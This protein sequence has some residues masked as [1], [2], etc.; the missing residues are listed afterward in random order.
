VL[1]I[2]DKNVT[3]FLAGR[4]DSEVESVLADTSD[5]LG[6]S[7]PE[8]RGRVLRALA[9]IR[10]GLGPEVVAKH[11]GWRE[12]ESF[13]SRLLGASGYRVRE[14]VVLIR[15]RV[16]IDLIGEGPIFVLSVDC[17]HWRKNHSPSALRD[18][19]LKQLSRSRLL[20]RALPDSR[21]IATV[22][23]GF[24]EP[25]GTFVN[26]VAVVPLR[27]LRNFLGSVESY[28]DLLEIV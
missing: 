17:K 24:S 4:M 25:A 22:I 6:L 26:G 19:A 28:T 12:F 16:Q 2:S 27:T 3:E 21:P 7:S 15:P 11:L 20:R 9:A 1:K 18:F 13:C 8:G 5:E 14:N 10:L 23:L